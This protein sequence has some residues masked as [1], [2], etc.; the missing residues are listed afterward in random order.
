MNT[1]CRTENPRL[2]SHHA[3]ASITFHIARKKFSFQERRKRKKNE[4]DLNDLLWPLS[5]RP[6]SLS[7]PF[8]FIIPPPT[9]QLFA[10]RFFFL[11]WDHV[12][13]D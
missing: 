9:N 2:L 6:F 10:G 7:S 8:G 12:F 4:M 13:F 5:S 3:I 11:F 1:T